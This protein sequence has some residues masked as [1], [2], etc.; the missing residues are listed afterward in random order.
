MAEGVPFAAE[1][2]V[3]LSQ[4]AV[5]FK[6]I[7]GMFDRFLV[8]RQGGAFL[9]TVLQDYAEIKVTESEVGL[10]LHRPTIAFLRLCKAA[11]VVMQQSQVDVRVG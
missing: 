1:L 9:L 8:R 7:G 11:E 4:V 6:E 10:M 3:Q 2:F 5:G